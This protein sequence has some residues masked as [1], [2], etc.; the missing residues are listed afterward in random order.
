MLDIRKELEEFNRLLEEVEDETVSEDA[1]GPDG[2]QP[3]SPVDEAAFAVEATPT[4]AVD[5]ADEYDEI[6][7]PLAPVG[8]GEPARIPAPVDNESVDAPA[9]V[10]AAHY[11]TVVEHVRAS[12]QSAEDGVPESLDIV[13]SN[14]SVDVVED[15]AD[16]LDL[17]SEDSEVQQIDAE[18]TA[19]SRP[20]VPAAFL[21]LMKGARGALTETHHSRPKE[22]PAVTVTLPTI[23]ELEQDVEREKG[24]RERIIP[25]ISDHVDFV[26]DHMVT[27]LSVAA[28]VVVVAAGLLV[29]PRIMSDDTGPSASIAEAQI[30]GDSAHL[31]SAADD[32]GALE[33]ASL[34]ISSFPPGARVYV[35]SELIGVT[36]FREITVGRGLQS[37]SIMKADY[38]TVDTVVNLDG[39]STLFFD[40]APNPSVQMAQ[41][42]EVPDGDVAPVQN[43]EATRRDRETADAGPDAARDVAEETTSRNRTQASDAN[44]SEKTVATGSVVITSDPPGATVFMDDRSIGETPV[45]LGDVP[46]GRTRVTMQRAGYVPYEVELNVMP[47]LQTPFHAVLAAMKGRVEVQVAGQPDLYVD[48]VLVQKGINP[49]WV[50]VLDVGQRAIT[51][52]HPTYGEW[53]ASIDVAPNET[54]P[55]TVDLEQHAYSSAVEAGDRHFAESRYAESI[56][57]YNRAL[58][59]RPGV[60]SIENKLGLAAKATAES[61]MSTS[62][63]DG[64]YTVADTPPELI[65]GLQALHANVV[66]PDQAYQEGIQGR[67]YVQFVVD[68][69]GRAR[70]L[71]IAKGL[72]MGCNEAAIRAVELSRF[73]PGTV[74]GRAVKVRHTVFV[75]FTIE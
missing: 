6:P 25:L 7:L 69:S 22:R 46:S 44:T 40:L 53:Q 26:Q 65:G 3:E 55:V 11:W 32:L 59:I 72:P 29:V 1:S 20:A 56:A 75:N 52:S 8:N 47:G 30:E 37:I 60:T 64:I 66:Y 70:D 71:T 38:A 31:L 51:L 63:P 45:A 42:S 9:E 15:S 16:M 62:N 41:V 12:T 21:S 19:L 74:D 50:E 5:S 33:N 54:T 2:S 36:P 18:E 39:E 23:E 14:D 57:S 35:S 4:D 24:I 68:E 27:A 43:T 17:T 61:G 73:R 28:V 10:P 67:V 13:S 58:S 48:G 49:G 34:S